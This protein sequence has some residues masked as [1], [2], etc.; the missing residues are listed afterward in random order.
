MELEE[1]FHYDILVSCPANFSLT[2]KVPNWGMKEDKTFDIVLSDAKEEFRMFLTHL[3]IRNITESPVTSSV[4]Q[5]SSS[6]EEPNH[7]GL[8]LLFGVVGTV[9]VIIFGYIIAYAYLENTKLQAATDLNNQL[10][11]SEKNKVP[12]LTCCHSSRTMTSSQF[13]FL[14]LY[15]LYKIFY[16]FLFTFTIFFTLLMFLLQSDVSSLNQVGDFQEHQY[17]RSDNISAAIEEHTKSEIVRQANLVLSM[18]GACGH[19]IEEL[20]DMIAGQIEDI[21][22][23]QS[24][25]YGNTSISHVMQWRYNALMQNYKEHL[26]N[27]TKDYDKLL[28]Q[29]VDPVIKKFERYASRVFQN[30]WLT[31]PNSLYNS[32]KKFGT[33]LGT[34][35]D[36][37]GVE[38]EF[39]RFLEVEEAMVPKLFTTNF[40]ER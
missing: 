30:E 12:S 28:T 32:S 26:E 39:L 15:I 33:D 8:A 31:F 16:S 4:G 29:Q 17:N 5:S 37:V 40:W 23:K 27:Y 1:L 18:Q 11:Y 9:A 36:D 3:S 24:N 10:K 38:A 20:S 6:T 19:Y 13:L 2:F 7:D 21:T 34:P 22:I 14:V 35:L 25:Q